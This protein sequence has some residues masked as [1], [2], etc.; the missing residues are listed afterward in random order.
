MQKLFKIAIPSVS[1]ML[2]CCSI[3][4]LLTFICDRL[5][6]FHMIYLAAQKRQ[7]HNEWLLERC[8]DPEFYVNIKY[9]A[10]VC[11]DVEDEALR[12]LFLYS[13]KEVTETTHICGSHPCAHYAQAVVDW[14]AGLS[15]PVM[16]IFIAIVLFCPFVLVQFVRSIFSMYNMFQSPASLHNINPGYSPFYGQYVGP[17]SSS[18]YHAADLQA[19]YPPNTLQYLQNNIERIQNHRTLSI[20]NQNKDL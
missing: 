12:S 8:K 16:I 15:L 3:L 18:F 4:W 13:L 17:D 5:F 14:V 2:T 7:T 19:G 20:M 9:H 1:Y 6:A 11:N 10:E